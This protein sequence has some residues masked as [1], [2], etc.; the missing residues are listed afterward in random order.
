MDVLPS[1]T[2]RRS[3]QLAVYCLSDATNFY[4]SCELIFRPDLRGKPVIVLSSNDGAIVA[5][6]AEAKAL[7]IPKF[8]PYFKVAHLVRKHNV[9]VFSSNFQL[10]GDISSR[11]VATI[12]PFASEMEPYSID[13]QFS[14]LHGMH[15]DL[16]AYGHEMKNRVW[17]HVRI[18]ICVGISKSKTLAKLANNAAKKIPNAHGVCVLDSSDKWDWVLRRCKTTDVWGVGK[19]LGAR[20]QEMG[21]HTAYELANA[22]TKAV[23]RR[24]SVNLERTIEELN[25]HPAFELEQQPPSKKQIYVTR[26]FGNK[27]AELA[28]ILEAISGHAAAVADKVRKQ[29]HL[30]VALQVFIHTSPHKGGY[31]NASTVVQLPY[32]TNDTREIVKLARRTAAQLYARSDGKGHLYAKAGVGVIEMVD[33]KYHQYDLLH[34]GQS[35]HSDMLMKV[36]DDIKATQGKS[37]IFLGAQGVDAKTAVKHEFSSPA[38][39]TKWQDIP[40]IKC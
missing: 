23:R 33:K 38:Y 8:E 1:Q 32:P 34:G 27:I 26:S 3:A 28:P 13:E 40:I 10:Y 29:N 11:I 22:D 24:S 12:A 36:V 31:H 14:S 19:Q 37:A 5:L 21:I 16:K 35:Q 18:P 20:L 39:T 6:S 7:G 2:A 25:G 30:A 9:A 4:S 17:E 15:V